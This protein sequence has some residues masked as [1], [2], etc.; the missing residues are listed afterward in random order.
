MIYKILGEVLHIIWEK[1]IMICQDIL[2]KYML[3]TRFHH[4]DSFQ[5]V[6]LI[7]RIINIHLTLHY[8]KYI[9]MLTYMLLK[10]NMI[11]TNTQILKYANTQIIQIFILFL[12]FSY[13][14]Y[15]THIN[16]HI[17]KYDYYGNILQSMSTFKVIYDNRY[18]I[19]N[20]I[21]LSRYENK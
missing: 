9:T 18:Y 15:K 14:I 3:Q 8:K 4:L 19:F 17:H 1:Y 21:L 13:I 11:D 5:K 20:C 10:F 16:I 7:Y 12:L 2:I 6:Y